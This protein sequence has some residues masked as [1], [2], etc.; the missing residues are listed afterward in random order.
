MKFA[1]EAWSPDYA[2]PFDGEA[3]GT[4]TQTA[5][6]EEHVEKADWQ[7]MDSPVSPLEEVLFVDG[8][9]RIDAWIWLETPNGSKPGLCASYGAGV[10]RCDGAAT[11]DHF[12]VRR[13][14]F[15]PEPA[16]AIQ[17]ARAR[18]EP[19]MV[20]GE[21]VDVL[22]HAV[23]EAMAQI[24]A[25][26]ARH[27]ARQARPLIVLDGPLRA[28]QHVPGA[29]GYVK[30]HHVRYLS[31]EKNSVVAALGPGQ[32]TPVFVMATSWTRYSWYLRL[33]H[34]QGHDWA[35]VV[36]C[37]APISLSV[38]EALAVADLA[39]ATLPRFASSPHKDARAP[40]NLYP[41]AGLE[42]QLRR[43]LGDPA[44]LLRDLRAAAS[45]IA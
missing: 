18:Y 41:I 7:P 21:G 37:E 19:R 23:G 38:A 40:Q 24:E 34:G 20:A 11:L 13:S 6:I 16:D 32:R 31:Q 43:R 17:T 42:R 22:R 35:G 36:R 9:Q 25:E 2:Q 10:V 4:P 3:P 27:A 1:V 33:P 5:T 45:R 14:F 39:S 15:T 28:S 29:I 8:V 30:T 12:T 26:V 44:L